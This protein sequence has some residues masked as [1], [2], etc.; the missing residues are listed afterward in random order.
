MGDITSTKYV[1]GVQSNSMVF[2]ETPIFTKVI[3]ELLSDT[4]YVALQETLISRPDMGPVMKNSG[5]IR[6]VRWKTSETGKSSGIR[7]IYYWITNEDKLFML[8]AFAK[9]EQ[10]TLSGKQLQALRDIVGRWP[11]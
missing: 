10:T 11:K 4:E 6:K 5:G 1:I 9:S 7:V 8:Y 3:S 2:I